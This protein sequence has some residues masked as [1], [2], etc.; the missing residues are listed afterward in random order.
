MN[1]VSF[2]FVQFGILMILSETEY[3]S[4][5]ETL[6]YHDEELKVVRIGEE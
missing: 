2:A 3:C 5:W 4:C 6:R 1:P